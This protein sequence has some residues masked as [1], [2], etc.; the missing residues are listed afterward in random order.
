MANA[1]LCLFC[2]SASAAVGQILLKL[3]ADMGGWE[4]LRSP[5]FWL[6]GFCYFISFVLWVFALSKVDLSI[7]YPFTA[8][9]FIL[10]FIMSFCVLGEQPSALK[11]AGLFLI[12]SGFMVLFKAGR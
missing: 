10:V 9:T 11:L 12:L 8:L 7:A 6:G 5:K 3:G 1:Y 4:I 2:S